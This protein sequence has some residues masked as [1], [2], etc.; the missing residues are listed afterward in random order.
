M[1]T[2]IAIPCMD[3]VPVAFVASLDAL[4]PSGQCQKY[5]ESGSLVY[6]SRNRLAQKAVAEGYDRVLWLDSDMVFEPDLLLALERTMKEENADLVTGLYFTRKYPNY[7]PV[8]YSHVHYKLN[9]QEGRVTPEAV[10]Y[11]DYPKDKP[12]KV[13]GCGMG[14]CLT[15]TAMLEDILKKKGLPF[16]PMPGF[17]E[18]LS[19]CRR[20]EDLGYTMVCDPRIKAGH[21]G[22]LVVTEE[23]YEGV[24]KNGSD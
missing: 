7:R 15:K 1:K 4:I 13:S 10:T 24:R 20:A 9:P 6:D 18:D 11:F 12:F 14:V 17:G 8:I 3:T 23:I 16:T 19:F 2:L 5:Y 21:V 22:Q